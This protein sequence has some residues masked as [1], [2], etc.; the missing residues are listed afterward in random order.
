[1][2]TMY[3]RYRTLNGRRYKVEIKIITLCGMKTITGT[4]SGGTINHSNNNI[5]K[6]DIENK[7]CA[8]IASQQ[9]SDGQFLRP[10]LDDG[11]LQ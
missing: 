3:N 1:M 9:H 7:P 6:N 11:A 8:L 10:F 4:A 2:T 5:N